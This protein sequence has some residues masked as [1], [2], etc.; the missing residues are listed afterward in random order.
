MALQ[1]ATEKVGQLGGRVEG[2]GVVDPGVD[3]VL[4]VPIDEIPLLLSYVIDIKLVVN[5]AGIEVVPPVQDKPGS[6]VV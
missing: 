3:Q 4:V 6:V 1:H 5:F 2:H